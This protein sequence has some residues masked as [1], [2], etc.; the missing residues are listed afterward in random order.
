MKKVNPRTI[1]GTLSWYK[2]SSLNGYNVIRVGTR[3]RRRRRRVDESF[4]SRHRSQKVFFTKNSLE[5]GKSCKELSWNHRTSAPYRSET[6]GI[7]E[8]KRKHQLYCC[9]LDWTTSGG[10][11]LWNAT[12]RRETGELR[13]NE[14]LGN[15][16]KDSLLHLCSGRIH[17]KTKLEFIN[18]EKVLPGIF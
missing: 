14:D 9:N 3:I 12:G 6:N 5:F 17:K 11:F 13:M 4:W 15:V 10:Q 1:T 2:I 8:W 18:L 7:A 16:S